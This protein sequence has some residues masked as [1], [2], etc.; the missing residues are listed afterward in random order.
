LD[1]LIEQENTDDES[2]ASDASESR[3]RRHGEIERLEARIEAIEQK[4]LVWTKKTMALSGALVGIGHGRNLEVR[5]GL[6]RSEDK[7][8]LKQSL[9][10]GEDGGD[11]NDEQAADSNPGL[12]AQL[13]VPNATGY[14][15]SLKKRQLMTSSPSRSRT[16]EVTRRL[17]APGSERESWL[18]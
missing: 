11:E 17:R 5:R 10:R 3:T 15:R 16:H 7:K 13:T 9:D 2:D 1:A 18:N 14:S 12:S 6:V 8:A 4:R